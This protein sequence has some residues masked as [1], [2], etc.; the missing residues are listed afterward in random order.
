MITLAH[1]GALVGAGAILVAGV[2]VA[3]NFK[4]EPA[5]APVESA[6]PAPPVAAAARPSPSPTPAPA[7]VAPPVE[8]PGYPVRASKILGHAPAR[9]KKLLGEAEKL[10]DGRLRFTI[11]NVYVDV[12]FERGKAIW[13]MVLPTNFS[14]DF[15][16][17][18]DAERVAAWLGFD[19][20][21]GMSMSTSPSGM[22]QVWKTDALKRYERKVEKMVAKR[23]DDINATRAVIVGLLDGGLRE[24]GGAVEGRGDVLFIQFSGCSEDFI[25]KLLAIGNGSYAAEFRNAHFSYVHCDDGDHTWRSSI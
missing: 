16:A 2:M 10:Q 12:Q 19:A 7:R 1:I 23:L 5:K 20:K 14:L 11:E 21:A 3:T 22:P 4:D 17:S 9:A 8:L 6:R 13:I 15:K 24:E 18:G 25:A